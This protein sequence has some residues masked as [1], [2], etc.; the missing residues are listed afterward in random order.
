MITNGIIYQ[1]ETKLVEIYSDNSNFPISDI[2]NVVLTLEN[3]SSKT[4]LFYDDFTLVTDP[5]TQAQVL[6]YLLTQE[7][8]LAWIPESVVSME[9]DV[10][11]E[12]GNRVRID[13]QAFRVK[14]SKYKEVLI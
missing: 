13:T 14:P 12:D 6:Q 3:G 10:L 2:K 5:E 4:E 11:S 8:T 1:G 9:L 7:D